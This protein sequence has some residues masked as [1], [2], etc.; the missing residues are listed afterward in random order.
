MRSPLAAPCDVMIDTGINRLGLRT[1]EIGALDGLA[2]ETLHSH[3]ACADED[4]ALNAIQLERFRA[5]AAQ[6]PAQAATAS[7]IPPASA[8]A[9]T[10]VSTSFVRVS[11]YTAGFPGPRPMATSARSRESRRRSSSAG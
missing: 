3:L 9:A 6:I 4:H 8:L 10:I 5:V 2:I 1:D 11:L 7:P